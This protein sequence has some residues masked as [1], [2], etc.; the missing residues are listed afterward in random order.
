MTVPAT[1]L[2]RMHMFWH[3]A[4]LSRV[5]RLAMS[6]FVAQGHPLSLHVYE[7][8]AGVPRGVELADAGNILP[9]AQMFRH[10]K[11]GSYAMFADW[12]RFC[13]LL[14]LGGIWADTDC[15]C[16]QPLRYPT[17]EVFGWEDELQIN[18]AIVG[19]PA[20]HE[21]AAW[22]ADCSARPNRI[23]PYDS[24]RII[25]R[26]LKRRMRPGSGRDR[27]KWGESG[28]PGFTAAARHLGYANLALPP[29]HFYPVH[30]RQWRIVFAGDQRGLLDQLSASRALHLW[31]EMMR[32]EPGFD[33]NGR[34]PPDSLFEQLWAR[35]LRSDT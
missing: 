13:V 28:P 17:A 15:V 9:V 5:E 19:L 8:P 6:S 31:N 12:F 10:R 2:A 34:F 14:R 20:G 18:T 33:K 35:Y 4:A 27:V 22:M 16:L 29:W 3:G 32:R 25:W 21:L 23:L 7:E 30:Y 24:W 11:T 1:G 26:K